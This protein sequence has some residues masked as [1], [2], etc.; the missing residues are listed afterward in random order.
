MQFILNLFWFVHYL[1]ENPFILDYSI[2][3]SIRGYDT[4]CFLINWFFD[5]ISNVPSFCAGVLLFSNKSLLVI[6]CMLASFATASSSILQ[7][8]FYISTLNEFNTTA[9][10][11][12][13]N[14]IAA[15]LIMIWS[16]IYN[17]TFKTCFLTA[18][19]LQV[20]TAC[21]FYIFSF[22]RQR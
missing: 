10:M 21:I 16:L 13:S 4:N 2:I 14:A 3:L 8:P 9:T 18:G 1:F 22:R 12:T 20:V 7:Q 11:T 15:I 5:S 17:Y 6:F 19:I